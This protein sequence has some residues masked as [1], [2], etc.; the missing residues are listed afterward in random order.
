MGNAVESIVKPVVGFFGK[1][2]TSPVTDALRITK[3]KT[4]GGPPSPDLSLAKQ[5]SAANKERA[6]EKRRRQLVA[7]Q[8]RLT[9]TSSLGA[10]LKETPLGGGNQIQGS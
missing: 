10:S 3:G 6:D 1:D 8:N 4:T 9:K 7:A 2:T 5:Q